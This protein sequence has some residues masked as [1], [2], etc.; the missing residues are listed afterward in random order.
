MRTPHQHDE[1]EYF[2]PPVEQRTLIECAE[3][4]RSIGEGWVKDLPRPAAEPLFK[5]PADSPSL[6]MAARVQA[7]WRKRGPCSPGEQP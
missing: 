5:T 1:A 7:A 6:L 4:G 2:A 3:A